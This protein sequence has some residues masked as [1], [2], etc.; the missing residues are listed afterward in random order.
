MS[1]KIARPSSPTPSRIARMTAS[2]LARPIPVSG[3]GVMFGAV[4]HGIPA[5]DLV[6]FLISKEPTIHVAV[7]GAPAPIWFLGIQRSAGAA[8]PEL[9][10]PKPD[11]A[12]ADANIAPIK[13]PVLIQVGAVDRLLPIATALHDLLQQAGKSV[14]IDVYEHGYHDFVLGP[15]GQ[16]R[17]ELPRGEVLLGGALDA[18]ER[19]VAFV[20][21]ATPGAR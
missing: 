14:R 19:S 7:L 5:G 3:S 12:V 8:R 18:L 16:T 4:S 21:A 2:S 10:V 1:A 6:A 11:P 9:D 20:K 15:Q 13:T 17:Q